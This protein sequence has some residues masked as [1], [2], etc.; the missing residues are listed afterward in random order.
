MTCTSTCLEGFVDMSRFSLRRHTGFLQDSGGVCSYQRACC[1]HGY[2]APG[3]VN[4][5]TSQPAIVPDVAGSRV[6]T[7]R[8]I[9]DSDH[10][11]RNE[12]HVGSNISC[13]V[14][15]PYSAYEGLTT[16]L[17]SWLSLMAACGCHRSRND[18]LAGGPG[19]DVVSMT[20][21]FSAFWTTLV[22][23]GK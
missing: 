20:C 23:G 21:S 22:Y 13:P 12:L 15:S 11:V 6:K 9:R 7:P 14:S 16:S 8:E 10:I 2:I 3:Q 19:R 5:G 17:L 4:G 1:R 18:A